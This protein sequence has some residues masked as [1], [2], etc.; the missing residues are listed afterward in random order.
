MGKI[1]NARNIIS[2]III[3][4]IAVILLTGCNTS[5]CTD[6]RNSI[7][8]AGLYS[9]ETL[10]SITVTQ[11]TIGGVGAPNDSLITSNQSVSQ[12]YLP[13]RADSGE[14]SFFFHYGQ[15]GIDDD[16]FNDTINFTYSSLPY[17][18][19]A[20]CGAMYR[21]II[22]GLTYTRHLIDSVGL[23]DSIITN[24]DIEKIHIYFRT[25][26]EEEDD[27]A[28]SEED[29]NTE[30]EEDEAEDEAETEEG[31]NSDN[32]QETEA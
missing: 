26:D 13:F 11:L 5:G 30:D 7:P 27:E 17:F 8:L 20:D 16:A 23:V 28:D 15:T 12:V 31:D 9:Y 18:A 4:T 6:N 29:T 25:A 2:L 10:Q 14:T 21:Y 32:N 3:Q 1:L 24:A 19:S 22:Q